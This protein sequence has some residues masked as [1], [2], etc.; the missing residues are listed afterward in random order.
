VNAA[1]RAGTLRCAVM[2]VGG[3]PAAFEFNLMHRGTIHNFKLGFR[4]KYAELSTGI[5]LK[6]FLLEQVLREA[7]TPR[8]LEYDFMGTTEPY[9]LNWTKNVRT[10]S[11][12]W[13]F[14]RSWH[15]APIYWLEFIAKPWLG[16]KLPWLLAGLRKTKN[17]LR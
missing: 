3:E 17:I 15:M 9:K 2:E 8:L 4:K 16:T 5:V 14:R 6:A 1:A 12:F 13:A 10:H 11:R 7:A